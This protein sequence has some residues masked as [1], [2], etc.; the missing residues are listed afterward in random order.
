MLYN[1]KD[2]KGFSLGARDGEIGRVKDFY[3]DDQQWPVRYLVA[4]TAKW[5]AGRQVLIAPHAICNVRRGD[6]VVEVDLTREQIRESPSI[7]EEVPVSRQYEREY[8]T[9]YNWPYYWQGAALWGPGP[10]PVTEGLPGPTPDEA[11]G[12]ESADPHLRSMNAV[13]G[14]YLRGTDGELGHVDDFIIDTLQWVVRYLVIDTRNWWPGK[15]VLISPD[16]VQAV[17]WEEATVRVD[18]PRELIR[19]APVYDSSSELTRD[20]EEKL[21]RHYS[22]PGYWDRRLAA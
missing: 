3:F 18:L 5:L 16:W 10:L 4:D 20:Y 15:K 9:Y 2:L 14:Y 21:H 22:R 17:S 8:F 12:A 1:T 6:G 19:E 11:V 7:G 13:A